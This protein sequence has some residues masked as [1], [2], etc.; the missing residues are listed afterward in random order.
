MVSSE[1]PSAAISTTPKPPTDEVG[2]A[3]HAVIVLL[4]VSG[5]MTRLNL[6]PDQVAIIISGAM[7]IAGVI[8]A[9]WLRLRPPVVP[10]A[11]APRGDA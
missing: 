2:A 4:G 6:T 1:G 7:T 9:A 3:I 5:L 8:R 10:V 11:P